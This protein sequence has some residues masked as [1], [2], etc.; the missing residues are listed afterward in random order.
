MDAAVEPPSPP[1][2]PPLLVQALQDV[3]LPRS[4][5]EGLSFSRL[6]NLVLTE[7]AIQIS[8]QSYSFV[9]SQAVGTDS[10]AITVAPVDLFD[11]A[12]AGF[13]LIIGVSSLFYVVNASLLEQG[14]PLLGI[15]IPITSAQALVNLPGYFIGGGY[16]QSGSGPRR[17]LGEEP[18]VPS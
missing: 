2:P 6:E 10:N 12:A 18:A 16:T 17:G 8:D 4:L 15:N 11:D 5:S 7:E 1:T 3:L 9:T 13:V 14:L